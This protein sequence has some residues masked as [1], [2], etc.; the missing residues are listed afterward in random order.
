[1]GD[2]IRHVHTLAQKSKDGKSGQEKT[3]GAE[4]GS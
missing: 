3:F 4:A 2:L 1:V